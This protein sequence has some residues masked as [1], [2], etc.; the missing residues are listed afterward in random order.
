M[1]RNGSNQQPWTYD[2]HKMQIMVTNR[3]NLVCKMCSIIREPKNS[4]PEELAMHAA[5]FAERQGFKEVE[6]GGGEPTLVKYFWP[7]LDRLCANKN[8]ETKVVTNALRHTDEMIERF[9]SYPGLHVQVSIDGIDEIHDHIRGANGAF[10]RTFANLEK[11]ASTGCI[12]SVNT[13]VQ[14]TNYHQMVE[15]YER[16]K[17][18]NLQ[19]HAFSLIEGR[20]FCN[21]HLFR[22]EDYDAVAEVLREVKTRGDADGHE[23]I[24][25]EGLLHAFRLRVQAP[26]Y[27]MHPG[28]GCS[29][30]RKGL[31]ITHDGHAIPCG[32]YQWDEVD[33]RRNMHKR[34]LDEIIFAD[35]VVSELEAVTG[36]RGCQGCST[37][38]YNWDDEFRTKVMEPDAVRRVRQQWILNKEKVRQRHP[39]VVAAYENIREKLT[40]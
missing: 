40:V 3:C 12:L 5:D 30:V 9:A 2:W 31:M 22:P 33:E 20:D 8:A 7:L 39:S 13:V 23:V 21:E 15:V 6:I 29:V 19:F 28:P 10:D 27:C 25:S 11:L 14:R 35:E 1:A 26:Q 17:S 38:C 36:P 16:F 24:L 37:M 32:H 4:L 18:L 34:T